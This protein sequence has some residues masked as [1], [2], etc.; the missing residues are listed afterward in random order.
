MAT[1]GPL[2]SYYYTLL[3]PGEQLAYERLL[4]AFQDYSGKAELWELDI[5]VEETERAFHFVSLDH[6]EIFWVVWDCRSSFSTEDTGRRRVKEVTVAYHMTAE[7]AAE[8]RRAIWDVIKPILHELRTLSG[9]DWDKVKWLHDRIIN[10]AD[11]DYSEGG[12]HE[13]LE[14]NHSIYGVFVNRMAVCEGYAEA[15]TWLLRRVGVDCI[16]CLGGE[17]AWN[18]IR[19]D[20]VY[21]HFDVT[22]DD[23]GNDRKENGI[24]Y[25]CFGLS[26]REMEALHGFTPR[27]PMPLCRGGRGNYHLRLGYVAHD[28]P[29]FQGQIALAMERRK[30]WLELR[31]TDRELLE[32]VARREPGFPFWLPKGCGKYLKKYRLFQ[33]DYPTGWIRIELEY[34]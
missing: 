25:R 27:F 20:G 4:T 19:I 22:W 13:K 15:M 16:T 31:L 3:S 30:R 9:E 7:E 26:D 34:R 33:P 6:P 10:W 8:S 32:Q 29:Q 12:R 11:Y 14:P 23:L 1:S 28:L 5:T 2:G 21:H 17:H 18:L 24:C